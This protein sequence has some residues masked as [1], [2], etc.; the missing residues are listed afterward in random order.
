MPGR[1]RRV[2]M[3]AHAKNRRKVTNGRKGRRIR[4]SEKKSEKVR[5]ILLTSEEKTFLQKEVETS[6]DNF[7]IFYF[8]GN[9]ASLWT[10]D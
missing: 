10:M 6:E 7:L 2:S 3:A 9:R 4:Q 5:R 1:P 8:I